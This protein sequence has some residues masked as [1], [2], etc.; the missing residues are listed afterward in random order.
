MSEE[1]E[2]M[3]NSTQ[4]PRKKGLLRMLE[5]LDRDGG[6]FFK[7]GIL[8]ILSMIP[9]F[10]TVVFALATGA[11][12]LLL[13]CIPTGMLAAPQIAGAAD[14]VMRSIRD[15]V[16]WWFW[17]SYKM[18]WKRN[19][20]PSLL[21]GGIFGLILGTNLYLLYFITQLENPTQEFWMLFIGLLVL[22]AVTQYYL[23]ML[24]CLELSGKDLLQ[25]CFVL[26]FCH[27]IKSLLAA[28]IQLIYYGLMLIWF[29]LTGV[30]L[31][32]TSVWLPMLIADVMISPA[33]D[34][35]MNL[36]AIYD[37]LQQDQWGG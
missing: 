10:L 7:A 9:F 30:I 20:R 28:L 21:P 31:A 15:Q 29:P 16:G 14:T 11:P 25:N 13:G 5:L 17:D 19:L 37:K 2:R 33:L 8:A 32:I 22:T 27:P 6:K 26:F 23:P 3:E 35:H 36:T 18:A 34:K 4:P 12:G 1:K 24:V